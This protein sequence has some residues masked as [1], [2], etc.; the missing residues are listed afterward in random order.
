M[1]ISKDTPV[2]KVENAIE[3]DYGTLEYT[4]YPENLNAH[5]YNFF[6]AFAKDLED[7]LSVNSSFEKYSERAVEI[8]AE[9]L[10]ERLEELLKEIVGEVEIK[11]LSEFGK[12]TREEARAKIDEAL[13]E[14]ASKKKIR[15]NAPSSGRPKKSDKDFVRNV[16]IEQ[17]KK[18]P[19]LMNPTLNWVADKL[20]FPSGESLR[21]EL[22][23]HNLNWK[24]LKKRT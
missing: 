7:F 4:F 17:V 21:K 16:V 1:K 15:M 24:E 20:K 10:P 18:A 9:Q 3:S 11:T 2:W 23:R 5:F 19:R 22:K 13:K 12:I 14:S 8:F 6:C